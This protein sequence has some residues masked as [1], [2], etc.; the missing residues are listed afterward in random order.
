MTEKVGSLGGGT[1]NQSIPPSRPAPPIASRS[2][3]NRQEK[4]SVESGAP[5]SAMQR[6]GIDMAPINPDKPVL[7]NLRTVAGLPDLPAGGSSHD[8]AKGAYPSTPGGA[9]RRAEIAMSI[10][11]SMAAA[12]DAIANQGSRGSYNNSNKSRPA[13]RG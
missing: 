4:N 11:H 7:A 10:I 9:K 2:G 5:N 6:W 13:F 12:G 8:E 3:S 1:L